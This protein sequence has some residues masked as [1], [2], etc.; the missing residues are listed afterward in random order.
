M[1]PMDVLDLPKNQD[2][3]INGPA[4]AHTNSGEARSY[5]D[6]NRTGPIPRQKQLELLRGYYASVSYMDAQIG[7]ILRELDCLNLRKKTII[8]LWSDHGYHLGEHGTWSK[9]TN[10]EEATRS[11]L[12][13]SAPTLKNT[14]AP[15]KGLVELVDLYPTICELCGLKMPEGLEGISIVPLLKNPN[16]AWKKAAFSQAKPKNLQGFT[17]R[18]QRY[19]Y[20]EWREDETIKHIEIYDHE[21]DPG[22]NNNIAANPENDMLAR[23]LKAQFDQGWQIAMP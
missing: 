22:E 11:V 2:L 21:T 15:T 7:K 19:R 17:M 16:R 14:G 4:Y 20:T 6:V 12:I 10:F 8:V 18:T 5:T 3:P 23:E 9:R 1:Y 13:V